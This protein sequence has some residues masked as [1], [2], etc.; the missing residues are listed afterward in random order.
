MDFEEVAKV[1]ESRGFRR[2]HATQKTLR[3]RHHLVE[4]YLYVN[5]TAGDANSV[6]VIHPLYKPFRNQFLAIEGIR[7]D[8]PWY[9]S[10]NMTKY[11]KEQHNGENPVPFGIPF[12]FDST[13][14]LNQF[15][16]VY[17]KILVQKPKNHRWTQK[18]S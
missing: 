5:R 11:P 7:N 2:D 9:H 8:D 6:L 16:G 13:I 18:V 10:S 17:L 12:G 14:A 1:L 15:L 3:Y 4:D